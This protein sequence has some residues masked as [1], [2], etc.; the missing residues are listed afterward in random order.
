[1][2]DEMRQ[3]LAKSFDLALVAQP[4]IDRRIYEANTSSCWA[5]RLH[6]CGTFRQG[7]LGD[8]SRR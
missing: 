2:P 6:A 1:M 8:R 7:M 3:T 4:E 5:G